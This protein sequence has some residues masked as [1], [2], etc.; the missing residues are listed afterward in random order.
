MIDQRRARALTW[1]RQQRE[2][3]ARTLREQDETLISMYDRDR[4]TMEQI[5]VRLGVT[6]QAVH[7]RLVAARKRGEIRANLN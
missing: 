4:L 2:T 7:Q 3:W 1:A 6:R 5:A